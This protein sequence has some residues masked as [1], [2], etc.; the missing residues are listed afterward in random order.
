MWDKEYPEY[1]EVTEDY[2][3]CSHDVEYI[4]ED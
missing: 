4:S 1:I 3:T 2:W